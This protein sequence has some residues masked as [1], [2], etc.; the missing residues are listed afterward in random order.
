MSKTCFVGSKGGAGVAQWLIS[1]MPEHRVYVESFLGT[2]TVLLTKKPAAVNIGIDYDAGVIVDFERRRRQP[3]LTIVCADS[4]KLL[5]V[6]KVESD[7]LIYCDPPYLLS[8][9][10]CKRSYYGREMLTEKEH[11]ILLSILTRLPCRVMISGY[12]SALYKTVLDEWRVS[13]F[14]TVNRRGKRVQEWCWMNYAAGGKLHDSRFVGNNF[15]DRQRIK[16]KAARWRNKYAALP[17]FERQAVLESLL[18]VP[19]AIDKPDF[20][21]RSGHSDIAQSKRATMAT[22]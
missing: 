17:S 22:K 8:T 10:S 21:V 9:R 7:W 18:A 19:A 12:L 5:P 3:G 4:L 11:R 13:T 2:G 6:L 20:P 16:R 15:T 1:L 14:W